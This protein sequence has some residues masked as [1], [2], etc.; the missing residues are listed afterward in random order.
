MLRLRFA[1][2]V[3]F[4][5]QQTAMAYAVALAFALPGAQRNAIDV[6][7]ADGASIQ[8]GAVDVTPAP[9][10]GGNG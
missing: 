4:D 6:S 5:S 10:A 7:E 9:A 3:E 2:D 8:R 1:F